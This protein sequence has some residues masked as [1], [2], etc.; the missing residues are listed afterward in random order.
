MHLTLGISRIECDIYT[1]R[2]LSLAGTAT[3][4][5][6]CRDK[7]LFVATKVCLPRQNFCRDEIMF[8]GKGKKN[9]DKTFVT[10]NI[11][12]VNH[13]FVATKRLTQQA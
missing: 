9:R 4:V 1:S 7:H 10:T 12:R 11:C 6:F 13:V 3:S 8:V 5:I 2:F